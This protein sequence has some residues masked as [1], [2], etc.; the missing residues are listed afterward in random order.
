M[1]LPDLSTLV[2]ALAALAAFVSV[3]AVGMP[4]LEGMRWRRA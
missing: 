1:T 3:I 2:I 4:L